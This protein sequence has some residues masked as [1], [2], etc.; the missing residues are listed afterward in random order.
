MSLMASLL[1]AR[2][3]LKKAYIVESKKVPD[4]SQFVIG[5]F[6]KTT[7]QYELYRQ[8][9]GYAP[10]EQT[11][12]GDEVKFDSQF[13][14][15]QLKLTPVLF[16]K[17]VR[18]SKLM[19]F[20]NQYKEVTDLTPQWSR[21]F[22]HKKNQVAANLDV[23]GFSSTSYGVNSEALYATSHNMGG[24]TF[25]NRPAV[26]IVYGVLGHRQMMTELRK[27]KSARGTPQPYIGQILVKGAPDIE[28]DMVAVIRSLQVAGTPNNDV[29]DFIRNRSDFR[30]IDYY[31]SASNWFAR[32]QD[33]TAHCLVG[34]SQMPYDIEKLARTT[35]LMDPWVASESYQVGWYDAHGTWGSNA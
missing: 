22:V 6:D 34:L 31:T 8:I 20:T 19:A 7:Q 16:T 10:P 27:Q 23:L 14:I 35:F 9:A 18:F 26:D 17:G 12:D 15:Y 33:E 2:K 4:Q 28:A 5:S 30:V 24:Q 1:L 29:N 11:D 21:A 25:S 32:A 13:A 3:V